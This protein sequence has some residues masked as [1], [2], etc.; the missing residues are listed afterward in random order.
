MSLAGKFHT[1]LLFP[2]CQKEVWGVRKW[3]VPISLHTDTRCSDAGW[4]CR[5]WDAGTLEITHFAL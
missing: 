3:Q 2:L 4:E 1:F 5:T